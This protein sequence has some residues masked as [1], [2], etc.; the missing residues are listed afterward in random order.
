MRPLESVI[1]GIAS[2]TSDPQ[3]VEKAGP[4]AGMRGILAP[5]E[6]VSHF[7]KLPAYSARLKV[8]ERQRTHASLLQ[9]VLD[10]E[11]QPFA[12][13]TEPSQTPQFLYRLVV[14][15]V[16]ILA[17]LAGMFLRGTNLFPPPVPGSSDTGLLALY[18]EIESVPPGA[19]VL[20]A[21]DFEPALAGE[22][23]MVSSTVIEHLMVRGANI[24]LVSTVPAGPILGQDLLETVQ[25]RK[26]D[27]SLAERVVNLGYLPGG[28]TSLLEFAQRPFNAAPLDYLGYKAWDR[29]ALKG[30]QTIRNFALVVVLTDSVETGR[31]WVEQV[32]PL[33]GAVPLAMVASAQAGPLLLPYFDSGQITGLLSGFM[34]GVMYEQHSGRVN[35]ANTL[36]SSY[37]TGMMAGIAMLIIGGVISAGINVTR[38]PRKGKM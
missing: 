4:L 6:P 33:M 34:G 13:S 37:Q 11:A 23:R 22:M 28:T 31:A 29:P 16:L 38:K 24:I 19:P 8:T 7:R 30:I 18:N 2:P 27:Y 1:P 9:N 5:E 36:W 25:Q 10:L 17:L 14:A 15:A 12:V 21:V 32:D 3:K 20:V 26:P 35:L